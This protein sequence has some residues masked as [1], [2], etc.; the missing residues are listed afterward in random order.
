MLDVIF[1]VHKMSFKFKNIGIEVTSIC[2]AKCV[3]CPRET[4]YKIK[5]STMPL[6]LY[7]KIVNDLHGNKI[8][9]T[10][11]LSVIGD[12]SCDKFLIER[13]RYNKKH[14]SGLDV[15]VL[16]NMGA[17]RNDYTDR[18]VEEV[19]LSKMR[20]SVFAVSEQASLKIYGNKSQ[21][22]KARKNIEYFINKNNKKGR[23]IPTLMYTLLLED[24]KNEMDELKKIYYDSMD[25]FEV[26]QPHSWSN[27]FPKLREIKEK[28]RKCYRIEDFEPSIKFNGDI[29]A[30][31]MDINHTIKYGNLSDS[32][33]EEIYNSDSY[34]YYRDL[35][36]EGLIETLDTCRNCSFLNED[37]NDLSDILLEM[38]APHKDPQ[39]Y[40]FT[41]RQ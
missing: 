1:G 8:E 25:E 9:K 39:L 28:R 35:N 29:C 30:C 32:T 18:I 20:F 11:R 27:I 12:P 2:N 13:L 38:K 14:A 19:L 7:K 33:I 37:E 23:P 4:H 31:S 3:I 17:W 5:P 36:R 10:V 41:R 15:V 6:K 26:W 24:N 22:G 21:A 34:K 40:N 16:S